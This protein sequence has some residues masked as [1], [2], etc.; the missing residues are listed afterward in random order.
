VPRTLCRFRFRK[1]LP[2]TLPLPDGIF[3]AS[4]A[5]PN[6][7]FLMALSG[8]SSPPPHDSA[9]QPLGFEACS[10]DLPPA[11]T[12]FLARLPNSSNVRLQRLLSPPDVARSEDLFTPSLFRILSP[13]S[14]IASRTK[15]FLFRDPGSLPSAD[16]PFGPRA[17]GSL[18]RVVGSPPPPCF[19]GP[20]PMA[21]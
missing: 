16:S 5:T 13:F 3:G 17:V 11:S 8:S 2:V 15:F 20:I 4:Q 18:L 7:T 9:F 19:L 10:D 6:G 1:T 14:L 12:P 21:S